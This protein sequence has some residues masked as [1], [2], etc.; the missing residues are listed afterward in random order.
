M[1]KIYKWGGV[2]GVPD[3]VNTTC[4]MRDTYPGK[5]GVKMKNKGPVEQGGGVGHILTTMFLRSTKGKLNFFGE[6]VRSKVDPPC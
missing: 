5:F 2:L 3:R 6:G 1:V 4:L